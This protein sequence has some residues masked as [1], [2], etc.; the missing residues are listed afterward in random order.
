MAAAP[1]GPK[2]SHSSQRSQSSLS[3]HSSQSATAHGGAGATTH[4]ADGLE[5]ALNA[6]YVVKKAGAPP[7]AMTVGPDEYR[8]RGETSR[9]AFTASPLRL[10]TVVTDPSVTRSMVDV[11]Q[12]RRWSGL[13]LSGTMAFR[14]L[15]W[16]EASVRGVKALGYTP[17][18]GD[19]DLLQ[20]ERAARQAAR[21]E[22][23]LDIRPDPPGGA[24]RQAVVAAIDAVLSARNAPEAQRA[25]VLAAVAAKLARRD[26][27]D[28]EL[29]VKVY[30]PSATPQRASPAPS[31]GPDRSRERPS[32]APAR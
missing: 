13:H 27:S 26:L 2:N 9:I 15:A 21:T 17:S 4:P 3:S 16:L 5:D 7:G 31:L 22:P 30:D 14:R 1:Q 23:A 28:P 6:R 10:A 29:R 11:A 19:L 20:H 32:P 25:A 12:A 18:P 24:G 8:F